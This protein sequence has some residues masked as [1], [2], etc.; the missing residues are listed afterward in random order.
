MYN[1]IK[2]DMFSFKFLLLLNNTR[3]AV[4]DPVRRPLIKDG[5]LIALF[6][7]SSVNITLAPQ[8]GIKPIKLVI[9]G[10]NILSF[11]SNFDNRSSP[12]YVKIMFIMKFIIK[13]NV[14]I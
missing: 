13:I 14:I 8:F 3:I 4:P 12:I 1:N 5:R 2:I 11:N 9:T 6:K 10:P 7:Y